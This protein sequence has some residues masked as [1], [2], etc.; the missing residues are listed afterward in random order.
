MK[1][2]ALLI[3]LW[4]ERAGLKVQTEDSITKKVK[5]VFGRQ[6]IANDVARQKI[7]HR[8]GKAIFEFFLN[9]IFLFS[10]Y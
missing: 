7:S 1:V 6:G 8:W 10:V 4:E 5:N 3:E 2:S 9:K